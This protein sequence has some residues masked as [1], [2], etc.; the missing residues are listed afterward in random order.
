MGMTVPI[1]HESGAARRRPAEHRIVSPHL[2]GGPPG[3]CTQSSEAHLAGSPTTQRSPRVPRPLRHGAGIHNLDRFG[4]GGGSSTTPAPQS[5]RATQ[6]LVDNRLRLSHVSQV[7]RPVRPVCKLQRIR[8]QTRNPRSRR[9][10]PALGGSRCGKTPICTRVIPHHM[11]LAA[12]T[13]GSALRRDHVRVCKLPM[14][15]PADPRQH[16]AKRI[17]ARPQMVNG[18]RI[19]RT[20]SRGCDEQR[21]GGQFDDDAGHVLLRPGLV[22]DGRD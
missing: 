8:V 5:T 20:T 10:A 6:L 17:A 19:R 3:E 22:D 18:C 12:A 11:S 7:R 21:A 2:A 16:W 15:D 13:W 9:P 4:D 14:A 1:A